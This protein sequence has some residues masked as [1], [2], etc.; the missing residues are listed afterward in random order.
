[1]LLLIEEDGLV[2][3]SWGMVGAVELLQ[4]YVIQETSGN[5]FSFL[6]EKCVLF[7]FL[8]LLL[9]KSCC[10]EECLNSRSQVCWD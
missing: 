4:S 7:F 8:L 10:I 5:P 1:M 6:L 9:C 3:Y 2:I